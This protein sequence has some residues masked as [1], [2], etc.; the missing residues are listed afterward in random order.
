MSSCSCLSCRLSARSRLRSSAVLGRSGADL[1]AS[2]SVPALRLVGVPGRAD[3]LRLVVAGRVVAL[4]LDVAG[5]VVALWPIASGRANAFLPAAPGRVVALWPIASGRANALRLAAAGRADALWP[6]ATGRA[7]ALLLAAAERVVSL[8]P[9]A[10]G[11][12]N[13]LCPAAPGRAASPC[14]AAPPGAEGAPADARRARRLTYSSEICAPSHHKADIIIQ[15][16]CPQ[17]EG[18]WRK[19]VF[20]APLLWSAPIPPRAHILSAQISPARGCRPLSSLFP[21]C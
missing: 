18:I 13:A 12:A 2:A 4:R 1:P 11:R 14:P 10:P 19:S 15:H 6:V 9:A 7:D 17:V 21:A 16:K 5:R 8:C 3:A 20:T